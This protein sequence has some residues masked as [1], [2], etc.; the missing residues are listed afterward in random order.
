VH[1]V[2]P[3]GEPQYEEVIRRLADE[4]LVSAGHSFDYFD[5]APTSDEQWLQQVDGA[6]GLLVL[7]TVPP[8]VLREAETLKVLSW[9]GTGVARFIDLEAAGSAGI[10][11]CNVP[12]YGAT[13][14]AEHALTLIYAVARRIPAADALVRD[15]KWEQFESLEISGRKL[16]VVGI[17]TIGR[18]MVE[19]GQG[20]GMEVVA[21]TRNP[22][23][24]RAAEIGVELVELD[25]LF[26][27]SDVVSLH[28]AHTNETEGII[29][30]DLLERLGPEAIFVNT[31]RAELVDNEA[32]DQLL[33]EGRIWGAG[34]DVLEEE[35]PPAAFSLLQ[36]HNL[37]LTPHTAFYTG[38][39][40]EEQYRV[41]I[42][43]LRAFA[44][45]AP[46]NVVT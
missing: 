40:A 18:R 30:R 38:P 27:T 45:G 5:R 26:E 34:L 23:A 13:A 36:R 4:L 19:L 2:C 14:V 33:A 28:L 6:D 44:D 42:S 3:D 11:V 32:L 12:S 17:G 35:P 46:T 41:A 7:F 10:A 21:W 29:S 22:S 15:G 43:N 37:V 16:G 39:S 9:S 31:A 20:L 1:F 25:Q 8:S 24:E